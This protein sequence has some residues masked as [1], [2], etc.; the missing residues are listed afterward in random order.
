[1]PGPFKE[2]TEMGILK[3]ITELLSTFNSS[4]Y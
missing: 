2:D 4:G 1:L 3:K